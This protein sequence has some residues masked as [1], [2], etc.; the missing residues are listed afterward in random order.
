[1]PGTITA[2]E[3]VRPSVRREL[4][5]RIGWGVRKAHAWLYKND[6]S[7]NELFF[8]KV[9]AHLERD[10]VVLD[11][12]CGGGHIFQYPWKRD[13]RFLIGCDIGEALKTNRNIASG[14][15]AD[16]SKLPFASESFD[17]I[18][19]RYVWEHVDQPGRVF[20]EVARVLKP[21]GK[22]IILTP[23]KY[24]Y[25]TAIS[26]FTPQWVH[27]ITATMMGI[28]HPTPSRR[29]IW[30]IAKPIFSAPRTRPVCGLS[31]SLPAR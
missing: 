18:F 27:G 28:A 7:D 8:D 1:M 4:K 30:Q 21:G 10:L 23:S 11:A 26:R 25:V 9:C 5:G 12:G 31:N 13:V 16:L 15:N 6:P 20:A 2:P 29:D 14:V 3:T 24:H 22:L 19:S 17:L